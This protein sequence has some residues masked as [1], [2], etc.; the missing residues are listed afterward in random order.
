VAGR[1]DDA[2]ERPGDLGER[3]GDLGER[4]DDGG[5]RRDDGDGRRDGGGRVGARRATIDTVVHH[6]L[7]AGVAVGLALLVAGLVLTLAGRGGLAV[8]SLKAPAAVPAAFHLRAA[9][10]YSLGLLVLILTP[11][12]RVLGSIVAFAAARDWRFV[13]VTSA[14]LCV[15]LVSIAVGAA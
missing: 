14:V 4:R 15:M 1:Y 3:P 10:F 2:G 6:T 8:A 5:A 13:A 7:V 9:G 12:I 11:F